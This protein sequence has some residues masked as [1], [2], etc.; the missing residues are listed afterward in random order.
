MVRGREIQMGGGARVRIVIAG[1]LS[2]L[3][4]AFCASVAT[5]DTDD[6]IAPSDPKNPQVD[7]GWQAGTCFSDAGTCSVASPQSQYFEQAGGHPQVGFTQFIIK[8]TTE[9]PVP[10]IKLEEPVGDLKNVPGGY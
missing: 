5:A 10:P 3:C 6:I 4:A 1:V 9:E 8:H 2:A 7:S